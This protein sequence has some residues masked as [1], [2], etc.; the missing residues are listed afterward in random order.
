M[1]KIFF[2]LV[3]LSLG[4]VGC[5]SEEALDTSSSSSTFESSSQKEPED[6]GIFLSE[7]QYSEDAVTFHGRTF[8]D[9]QISILDNG[10]IIATEDATIAGVFSIEIPYDDKEDKEYELNN[11]YNTISVKSKSKA[12]QTKESEDEASKIEVEKQMKVQESNELREKQEKEEQLAA[13]QKA[14]EDEA[15]RVSDEKAA[16]IANATREQKNALNKAKDY[17]NYTAFS[18]SGLYDQLIHEQYPDD[19]AQFAI[20]NIEVDW[21]AQALQKAKDYLDYTSFSDQGLY[22]QLIHEGFTAEQSQYAI[23]NLP[24]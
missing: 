20:D 9:A 7:T 3:F 13:E 14:R 4:I 10:K 22:D 11:G 15:K 23:D 1:K 17:L 19:A 24:N 2:G 21:N 12:T 8:N 18:K 5:S 6:T 16:S